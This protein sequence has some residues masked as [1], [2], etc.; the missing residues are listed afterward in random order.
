MDKNIS[1]E[2]LANQLS[3]L[4]ETLE[5]LIEENRRLKLSIALSNYKRPRGR[6]RKTIIED[7]STETKKPQG[8]PAKPKKHPL[9]V[10]EWIDSLKKKYNTMEDKEALERLAEDIAVKRGE[11]KSRVKDAKVQG[12]IKT[13]RNQITKARKSQ[14]TKINSP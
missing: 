1:P 3:W 4:L 12:K 6:P 11:R 9:S 7:D 10:I 13:I 2:A 14:K 8:R 5:N